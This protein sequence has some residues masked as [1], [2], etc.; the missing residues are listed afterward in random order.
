MEGVTRR[1]G[2]LNAVDALSLRIEPGTFVGLLGRN[3][4]GKTTTINMATGLLTPSEGRIRV[5]GLDVERQPIEIKRRIGVLSQE[6]SSLEFLTG[7]QSLTFVGRI[8]GLSDEETLRRAR[9]LFDVLDLAAAPGTLICDYSYGMKKKLG[10]AAALIHGP[11]L[12]FLDEP[13]EGIDPV[14]GRTIRELLAGLQRKG[15]SILMT[16]HVLEIVEKL[17]CPIAILEKGRLM[18]LGSLEELRAR[19]GP[20]GTEQGLEELF[21]TLMGGAKRGE[22]SWL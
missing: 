3:G 16:S 21:V 6:E 13:F 15:I 10:L 18:G 17:C 20:A 7:L 22:L 19:H 5:L 4:A 11:E 2:A 12:L 9:E 14:T 8:H 1:F